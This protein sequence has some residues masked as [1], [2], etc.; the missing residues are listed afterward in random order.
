MRTQKR[1]QINILTVIGIVFFLANSCKKDEPIV[2]KDPIITWANPAAITVETPLSATQLNATADV[3]GTFIY[4]PPIGTS[5]SVGANQNLKVDFTPTDVTNYNTASKTVKIDVIIATVTDFDGN[6]YHAISIGNQVWLRENL[7]VTHYRNGD[8]IRYL[9]DNIEWCSYKYD[10]AF[11]N[12]NN[13][14]NNVEIYGRLYS[15]DAVIDQRS[16]APEGWHIPNNAEWKTLIN[17]LGG[18]SIAGGKLKVTGF[19]YWQSPNAGA[20][21]A[22]GFS[23]FPSG[24]RICE[25][26]V[27]DIAHYTSIGQ[28]AII[29]S[30]DV[31]YADGGI[32]DYCWHRILYYDSEAVDSTHSNCSAFAVRCIKD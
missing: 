31:K 25:G 7:K 28:Y 32:Y 1:I 2:K 5:L 26:F 30:C 11:C 4:T 19:D 21:N 23:A 17:Y 8:T 22:S 29:A 12:Y 27:Y 15:F 10:G 9:P 24:D 6:V 14:E 16:I 18:D 3:A 20:T 13:D